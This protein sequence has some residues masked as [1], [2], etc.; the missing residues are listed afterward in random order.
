M[1]F[2]VC[3]S[4]LTNQT[5]QFFLVDQISMS[6]SVRPGN[7]NSVLLYIFLKQTNKKLS[8]IVIRVYRELMHSLEQ[9]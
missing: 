6:C 5:S 3:F 7:S 4:F 9:R 1:W 2:F 8:M